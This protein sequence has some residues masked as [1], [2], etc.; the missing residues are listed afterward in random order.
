MQN[1]NIMSRMI[2]FP[3][4]IIAIAGSFFLLVSCSE[5]FMTIKE[6]REMP[7]PMQMKKQPK[8]ALVLGGGAFHGAA[9]LGVIKVL[10]DANVPV[11]LIVGTSAG[12]FVGALYADCPHADSLVNLVETT[13]AK[14]VFDFSLF[15]SGEGLVSGKK[16]QNFLNDHL[17]ELMIQTSAKS[18]TGKVS[19]KYTHEF[20]E[21]IG[22]GQVCKG[23][24]Q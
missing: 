2:K 24:S 12:S 6:P 14:N 19:C 13:K 22:C 11:D 7:P 17:T 20:L 18:T 9:H 10:E 3:G 5:K 16:L 15:R 23:C 4:K 1:K 21:S 8:V